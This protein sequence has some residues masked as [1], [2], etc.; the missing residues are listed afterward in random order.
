MINFNSIK[1]H[2]IVISV[3][4]LISFAYF[5]PLLEGKR[6]DGHDVKTWIGM[7]KEISDYRDKTGDEALWTNSLFSGMPAYQISVK[8]SANLVRYVDKIITFGFPRPANLL[9]LYLLGF[10]LLLVSLN[11]DYRIA[12]V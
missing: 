5:S 4:A 6:I 7:S 2:L 10:Y 9:F 11:I 1:P 8:Y 12:A 3:F